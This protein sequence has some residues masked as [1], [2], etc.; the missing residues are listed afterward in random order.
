MTNHSD[1]KQNCQK[2]DNKKTQDNPIEQEKKPF[3]SEDNSEPISP[4]AQLSLE[5]NRLMVSPSDET[6]TIPSK[7]IELRP[8]F[9][10]IKHNLNDTRKNNKAV[11]APAWFFNIP[12]TRS[13]FPDMNGIITQECE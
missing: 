1:K 9:A 6:P 13:P 4:K 12:T 2:E 11:P 7:S 8:H 10:I 3:S 5:E